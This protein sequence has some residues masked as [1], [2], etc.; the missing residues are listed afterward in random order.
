[1]DPST[2]PPPPTDWETCHRGPRAQLRVILSKCLKTSVPQFPRLSF[3]V[4]PPQGRAQHTLAIISVIIPRVDFDIV[5]SQESEG[6]ESNFPEE[7]GI[8]WAPS[9]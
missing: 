2:T 9:R 6:G 7:S 1:M 4:C 8:H 3:H 5:S